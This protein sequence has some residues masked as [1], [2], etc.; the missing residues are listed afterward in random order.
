MVEHAGKF[1]IFGGES[2]KPYMYHNSVSELTMV[3]SGAAAG[4]T[5]GAAAM[6]RGVAAAAKKIVLPESNGLVNLEQ[7]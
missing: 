3:R 4:G 1:Y 2:Y 6:L 7:P 5:G